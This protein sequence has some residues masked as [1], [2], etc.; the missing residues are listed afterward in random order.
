MNQKIKENII[1][2][3][4]GVIC[5]LCSIVLTYIVGQDRGYKKGYKEGKSERILIV[6]TDLE[7]TDVKMEEVSSIYPFMPKEISDYICTLSSELEL[8]SDL[9]VAILMRENPN[10]VTDA[11]HRNTDGTYDI[12]LFQLNDKWTW[13]SFV[14]LFWDLNIDFDPFNWKHNTFL[15]LHLIKDL[16]T[17]L[18]VQDE[19]IMAYNAGT[20]RVMSGNIPASTYEYLAAV[21]NNLQLLKKGGL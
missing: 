12:G 5:F 11:S 14:P 21:K 3:V 18:K 9:A 1:V 19:V 4:V 17:S 20:G 15:A 13:S 6:H 10:F 16:S 8:D 7:V 2:A